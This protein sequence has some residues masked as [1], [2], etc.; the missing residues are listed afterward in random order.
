MAVEDLAQK[1]FE[2]QRLFEEQAA[3]LRKDPGVYQN[4]YNNV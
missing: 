3:I 1:M 4:A 2:Y